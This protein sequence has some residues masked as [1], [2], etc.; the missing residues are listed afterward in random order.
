MRNLLGRLLQ[1]SP[2]E[3]ERIARAWAIELGGSDRH[4]DVS[5]LY[6]TMTDV[7]A[8][9]DVWERVS[10]TGKRLVSALDDHDGTSCPPE[11]VAREAGIDP[12]AG[13]PELRRLYEIGIISAEDRAQGT[14]ADTDPAVFLPREM[15]LM[16]ER[17]ETERNAPSP[18]DLPLEELLATATYPEIEEAATA[19]G[20]RVIPAMHARGELVGIISEQLS[21]PERVERMIAALSG[22]A[23]NAWARLTVAGGT[24]ALD[25][26][27]SPR[28][29]PLLTRR[30]ILRELAAPL[31]VWHGYD[32]RGTRL[33]IVP[34]S[35]LHPQ[36]VA[37]EQPPELTV[38]ESAEVIEP[39]WL[40]PYAAAW[41]LLTLL[42]EVVV[43]G[44]RWRALAEGDPTM[45]RRLRK[46]LWRSDRETLDLPTG[47]IPFIVR[48]G[49]LMGVLR[50][51]D[52]RAVPGDAAQSW[53]EHAFTSASQRMVAAWA[54]AE[55]WV[56]GRERVDANLYGASWPTFRATLIKAIGDLDE[57]Q[58]YEQDRFVERLLKTHPDLLRQAQVVAVG[59]APRRGRVDTS[60]DAH[61][62]REQ[63]LSL[64]IGTTLETACVWLG[65]IDRAYTLGKRTP[66][67]R[68][69]PFGRWIA[70]KRVEPVMTQLGQ[71]PLGVGANFQTLL[72]RQT[73]RRVWAL[74]A[75]AELQ[76]LDRVSTWALTA[77]ALIRALASGLDLTQIT[78][79]L[80]RQNGAPLPQNVAYTLNE[81]DRGYRRVWLRRA[82]LLVPDEGEESAPIADALK[83]AGLSPEVLADGRIALVYDEPDAGERLYTAVAR[84]LR[85]RG[86]APL[87][88]PQGGR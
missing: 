7:W 58:W 73:P 32:E 34:Q 18:R 87:A 81:W 46:K 2:A 70:G 5:F 1:R 64:V 68:V 19:W 51:V 72:F 74:S 45:I 61:D 82:V 69:T 56:E 86:F 55:E 35:I 17:V 80:E 71:A 62:R 9:R 63:I 60:A 10:D 31:L 67:L 4:A 20:A 47:Y 37:V 21:R 77:E 14:G 6:R 84:A 79:F 16:I 53:R 76:S 78:G 30:R 52:D 3:L 75:F 41:D 29:V 24:L 42:R 48:V 36:P 44:P 40:F 15:G 57:D 25:E 22:P 39:E 23:R 28:D 33:V 38:V 54:G 85:E 65:L 11:E 83:D 13:L 8:V 66:V 88:D 50:D 59:H 26:L 27:L 43:S 12:E 49:A